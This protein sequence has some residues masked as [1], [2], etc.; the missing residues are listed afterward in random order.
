VS[1]NGEPDLPGSKAGR[2]EMR[3]VS[4]GLLNNI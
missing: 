1:D 3:K 2:N 4:A